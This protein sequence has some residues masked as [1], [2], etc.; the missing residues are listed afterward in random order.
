M[1]GLEA[2]KA[3]GRSSSMVVM[4]GLIFITLNT[5]K[6]VK[7]FVSFNFMDPPIQ[8]IF[9]SVQ[10]KMIDVCTIPFYWRGERGS[11]GQRSQKASK[12]SSVL[13]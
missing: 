10:R 5:A 7:C 1:V 11:I 4:D 13:L 3:V 12:L 6:I 9:L 8:W 2:C